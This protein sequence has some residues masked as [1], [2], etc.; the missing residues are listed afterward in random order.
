MKT[1]NIGS[2]LYSPSAANR[3]QMTWVK[4]RQLPHLMLDL[5]TGKLAGCI[6][7]SNQRR[8]CRSTASA[9]IGSIGNGD[10]RW[11]YF[12]TVWLPFG[13]GTDPFGCGRQSPSRR[14]LLLDGGS[15]GQLPIYRGYTR[16]FWTR[17]RAPPSWIGLWIVFLDPFLP[18]DFWNPIA[19][20]VSLIILAW[21][22]A[23]SVQDTFQRK[24]QIFPEIFEDIEVSIRKCSIYG[25]STYQKFY[26][27]RR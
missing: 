23:N 10:F 27:K 25:I 20:C 2:L 22:F 4:N 14:G 11:M 26:G 6:Q 24:Q 13:D 19:E 15:S 1:S 5:A 18:W 12:S 21:P 16:S 8:H 9:L 3:S 17:L 7:E